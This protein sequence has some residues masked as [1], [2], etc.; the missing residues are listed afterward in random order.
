MRLLRIAACAALLAACAR[1]PEGTWTQEGASV[2]VTAAGG[3]RVR[4]EVRTDGI[5]RVTSQV[6]GDI[7]LPKSLM[8]VDSKNAPPKFEARKNGDQ[9]ELDT[10]KIVAR[11][12]L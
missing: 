3:K 6:A 5:V 10:G 1:E 9:V 12:S 11:V 2:S 7:D 8:V 4:L